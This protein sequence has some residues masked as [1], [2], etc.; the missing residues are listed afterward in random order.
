MRKYLIR[1]LFLSLPLILFLFMGELAL[2]N[3]PNDYSFKRAYL[4]KNSQNLK[5][6]V[7]GSSHF[8]RGVNPALLEQP[9]FNAAMVSQS[10]DY[11]LKI[12]ENYDS[13]FQN[14][15]TII[16]PISYFSLFGSLE[17]GVESWRASF[18]NIYYGI[19]NPVKFEVFNKKGSQTLSKVFDFYYSDI[20]LKLAD[21]LGWG[22]R[23]IKVLPEELESLGLRAAQRHT[24]KNFNLLPFQL[25]N[26]RE[27]I[28]IANKN[29]WKLILVT[30][31]AYHS[32]VANLNKKQL[33][34][35][36]K[37]CKEMEEDFD[38]VY[39]YNFLQDNSFSSSDFYDADH[40]NQDGAN[41]FSQMLNMKIQETP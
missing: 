7:L 39:Y 8:Y 1:L 25:K 41:K 11:D 28:Q 27:I 36:I 35:T 40:L 3:I 30:P 15:E 29:N 23:N 12:L 37:Y 31:P 16:L 14:L 20:K 10:L 32:Y 21:S 34:L 17:T 13:E 26:F 2:R 18:Y 24:K 22:R 9:A 19:G 33:D 6:L 38:N 4:D 5:T